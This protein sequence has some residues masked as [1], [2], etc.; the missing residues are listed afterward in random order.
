MKLTATVEVES[1][2]FHKNYFPQK[3]KYCH[4]FGVISA[5]NV[6]LLYRQD[7]QFPY[8]NNPPRGQVQHYSGPWVAGFGVSST[9]RVTWPARSKTSFMESHRRTW[10]YWHPPV[11][12]ESTYKISHRK[13]GSFSIP[14]LY[15]DSAQLKSCEPQYC[16]QGER[17]LRP[18]AW[19][20][21]TPHPHRKPV[22]RMCRE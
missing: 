18:P 22:T 21:L 2:T 1:V 7:T 14:L 17:M 19:K 11:R 3:V 10:P 12:N 8:G 9:P 15:T 5:S 4:P 6:G 16:R 13:S 20:R